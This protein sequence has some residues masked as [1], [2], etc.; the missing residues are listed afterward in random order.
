MPRSELLSRIASELVEELGPP[1]AVRH[2]YS[3][4]IFP[5]DGSVTVRRLESAVF[6]S[7]SPSVA[8]ALCALATASEDDSAKVLDEIGY[9]G[10]PMAILQCGDSLSAYRFIA[11]RVPTKI[12]S[13]GVDDAVPWVRQTLAR[14]A[15]AASQLE[16]PLSEGR[17]ILI[18]EARRGLAKMT[19]GLIASFQEAGMESSAAAFDAAIRAIRAELFQEPTEDE[20]V[21]RLVQPHREALRFPHVPLEAVAELYETLGLEARHRRER[22]IAYTPAWIADHLIGRLPTTAFLV[23]PAVDPTCGSGTFLVAYLDRLVAERARRRWDTNATDL[24]AA[25]AG[26]DIDPVALATSRLTLDL[27]AQR[28]GHGVQNWQLTGSDATGNSLPTAVLIGNLPFGYRTHRGKEDI[29]SVILRHWLANQEETLESLAL[30]LPDSFAYAASSTAGAR[31]ELRR[32]FRIDEILELPEEVFDRTSAATLAVIA[33]RGVGRTP[34]I[35]HIR[36]RDLPSFRIT[37]IPSESFVTQLPSTLT[38]PWSLTPFFNVLERAELRAETSLGEVTEIRLGYQPYGSDATF[39]ASPAASGPSVLEDS[40]V[41]MAF[42]HEDH[43]SLRRLASPA[44]DLRRTGPVGLYEHP[45]LLIRA[46]TNRHQAARLAGLPDDQGL[47]FSDKFIGIWPTEDAP[48]IRGL[49]A[50][51]Q[52]AFCELWLAANNPS[53]KIRVGILGRLPVPPLPPDWWD[54]AACL[55]MPNRTT[56]S[57][58]WPPRA[59]TLLDVDTVHDEEWKWFEHVVAVAFGTTTAELAAIE[60]YLREQLTVGRP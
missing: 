6:T 26:M 18:T 57:P 35:R 22:G 1:H 33:N 43:V 51:L 29:S 20:A 45:K 52:T 41:F 36:R 59:P 27:F 32:R 47:W 55:A 7:P 46:T 58:R 30:L 56:V 42:A 11:P 24:V 44:S 9:F 14:E 40:S 54:R 8:T 34:V 31:A 39:L 50:Y 53:R 15:S 16:L 49:A 10:G 60:R 23:G 5:R 48:P 38:D 3:Y 2:E 17:D 21:T 28:L 25:V 13:V 12:E 4:P 37:R 19:A